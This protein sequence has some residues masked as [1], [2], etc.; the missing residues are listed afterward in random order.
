MAA[1]GFLET[2][3]SFRARSGNVPLYMLR[4]AMRVITRMLVG[5]LAIVFAMGFL[6]RL[7]RRRPV[8]R[9]RSLPPAGLSGADSGWGPL[10]MGPEVQKTV[11]AMTY[12]MGQ[13]VE[14]AQHDGRESADRDPPL[15]GHGPRLRA[16]RAARA[17][18][19]GDELRHAD[20]EAACAAPYEGGARA[21]LHG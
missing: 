1:Q 6:A 11:G 18:A 13:M 5:T 9:R 8:S 20:G 21:D 19:H 17:A 12:A 15:P 7:L 10:I 16:A 14:D 2:Q 4:R 3:N